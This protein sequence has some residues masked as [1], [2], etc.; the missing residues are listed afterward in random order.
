MLVANKQ[1]GDLNHMKSIV[2]NLRYFP[3][4][5]KTK[6]HACK[7]YRDGNYKVHEICR[8]YHCSKAP[9]M[10]FWPDINLTKESLIS[11]SKRPLT[12]HPNAHT[13][14][15]IKHISNLLKRNPNITLG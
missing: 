15:E 4:D 3:H 9:L 5:I 1:K 6:F 14:I 7:T 10:R 2:H 8:L 12:K 13:D 11:H